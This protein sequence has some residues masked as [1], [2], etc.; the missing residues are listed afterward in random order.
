MTC[1]TARDVGDERARCTRVDDVRE[2][3]DQ[4]APTL[5]C[6]EKAK[7]RR[8]VWLRECRA[9]WNQGIANGA[10]GRLAALRWHEGAH[11]VVEDECTDPIAGARRDVGEH[12]RGGERM[13]EARIGTGQLRHG[14]PGVD[15]TEDALRLLD[16]ELARDR[17]A[18]ARR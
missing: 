10:Q 18:A 1:G 7:C 6:G 12:Q 5:P 17:L 3:N 11:L 9:Y 8:V 15:E 2:E 14:A 16:R 13:L 4:S